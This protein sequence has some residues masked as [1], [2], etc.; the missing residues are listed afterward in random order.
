MASPYD[1]LAEKDWEAKTKE[2]VAGHPLK[3]DELVD[4]VL[5]AWNAIFDTKLGGKFSIGT[6]INPKP[7]IMGFL[8]HELIPLELESRYPGVWRTDQKKG[9]KDL[10]Y[11]PDAAKSVELKTSSHAAQIFGNRSYA[12]EQPEGG[13]GK[14]KNGYY[15][16]VN[17]QSFKIAGKDRPNISLIRFGWLDHTDWIGQAAATGQQARVSPISDRKKLI[18][19]Y[20]PNS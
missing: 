5:A 14:G 15:L 17:F 6:D 12:Q 20:R 13:G 1:G 8:M 10:N 7:Q 19:L 16:A 11:I 3:G 2:L 4:V 9:D 18:T